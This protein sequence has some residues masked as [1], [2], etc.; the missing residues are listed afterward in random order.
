MMVCFVAV[1]GARAGSCA[2]AGVVRFVLCFLF[3]GPCFFVDGEEG[4]GEAATTSIL[5]VQH[6]LGLLR[7]PRSSRCTI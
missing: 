4:G 7:H 3:S 6:T 2:V 1:Y 5:L